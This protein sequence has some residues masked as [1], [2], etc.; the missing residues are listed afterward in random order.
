MKSDTL[1][2]SPPLTSIDFNFLQALSGSGWHRRNGLYSGLRITST[3]FRWTGP[4]TESTLDFPLATHTDLTIRIRITNAA[5]PDILDSVMLK[6]NNCP[7]ALN[8]LLKRGNLAVFEG[9]IPQIVLVSDRPFTRLTLSVNRTVSLQDVNP[10][11]TDKRVVGLAVQR[12]QIFPSTEQPPTPEGDYMLFPRGD[13]SWAETADFLQQHLKAEDKLAAPTEFMERFP[14]EFLPYSNSFENQ[15]NLAWVVIHKGLLEEVHSI[16]LRWTGES[17]NPVFANEVFVIFSSC[18]A[19]PRLDRNSPHLSSF[20]HNWQT[21]S[22]GKILKDVSPNI[23]ILSWLKKAI[24]P[25]NP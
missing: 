15:P 10:N 22:G 24:H 7:I 11:S 9:T 23:H 1:S 18:H 20:W 19:L 5:A 3:P 13:R 6:A 8:T 17:L 14:E 4:G 21:L 12:I 16:S 25:R 2:A